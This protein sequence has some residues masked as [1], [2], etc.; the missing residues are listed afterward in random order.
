MNVFETIMDKLDETYGLL[1]EFE[2]LVEMD[3]KRGLKKIGLQIRK[4][5][6]FICKFKT[7][8]KREIMKIEKEV[9][10]KK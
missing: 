4:N 5:M 7:D 3:R 9:G 1:R 2:V 8:F 6:D 10:G